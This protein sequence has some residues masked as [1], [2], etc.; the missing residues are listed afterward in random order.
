MKFASFSGTFFV[1]L[2]LVADFAS[3]AVELMQFSP[4][5]G[6]CMMVIRK[7]DE[8]MNIVQN[9]IGRFNIVNPGLMYL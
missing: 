5:V 1:F 8:P 7:K 3:H 9:L 6:A 4:N 2:D